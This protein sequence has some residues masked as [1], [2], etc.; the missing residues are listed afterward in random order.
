MKKTASA[1]TKGAED[2]LRPSY[3]FD[4]SKAQ[5]NRCAERLKDEPIEIPKAPKTVRKQGSSSSRKR[6]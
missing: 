1:R 4:Y 2:E 6:A 3:D 5:P